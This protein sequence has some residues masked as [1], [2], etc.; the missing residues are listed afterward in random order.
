MNHEEAQELLESY[1]D[2]QLDPPARDQLENH[3]QECSDCRAIMDGVAPV[4][5]E[6]LGTAD[7]DERTLRRSVRRALWRTV[8]DAAVMLIALG[9]SLFIISNF[10]VHPLLMNRGD[11]AEAVARA[12]FDVAGMFNPG[13]FVDKFTVDSGVLDRTFTATVQMPIGAAQADLGT[14]S[15]R[16]G[17]FGS[18]GETIWPFAE[19]DPRVGSAQELLGR[20]GGGTVATV[21]VDFYPAIP[22]DQAQLLADSPGADVSVVWAGFLVTEA[23]PEV[24]ASDP[25]RMLGYSTCVGTDR[26]PRSVFG[27]SSGSASRDAR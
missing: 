7:V 23:A 2:G 6:A 9:L 15:S 11:R 3:L 10:V 26:I 21:S 24:A 5:L 13:A 18:E 19:S 20:L 12:T 16:I 1:A 8:I 22:I 27:G 25:L 17:L 14:V 4:N